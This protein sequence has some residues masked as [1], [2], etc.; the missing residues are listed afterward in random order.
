MSNCIR[1]R[2]NALALPLAKGQG[3]CRQLG[4]NFA[5]I[6]QR[7]GYP[8]LSPNL[9]TAITVTA[10]V[11]KDSISGMG[12]RSGEWRVQMAGTFQ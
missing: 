4:K 8:C 7:S 10:A 6:E 11:S 2:A 1:T 9:K 12:S 5:A 3:H